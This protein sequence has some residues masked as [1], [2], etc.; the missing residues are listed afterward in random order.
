MSHHISLYQI[1][2]QRSHEL[3]M[4]IE[5]TRGFTWAGDIAID[6]VKFSN[7]FCPPSPECD[8]ENGDELCGFTQDNTDSFNWKSGSGK[9]VTDGTGMKTSIALITYF[10]V[11]FE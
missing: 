3:Q 11:T 10:C 9:T 7:G 6:D 4:I 1:H 8:F 2:V 5:A